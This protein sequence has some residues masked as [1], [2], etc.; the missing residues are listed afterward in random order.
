NSAAIRVVGQRSPLAVSQAPRHPEVDQENA[1]GFESDNQILAATVDGTDALAD[2]LCGDD[3]GRERPH[4]AR[5]AD[6]S[7]RDA[8]TLE[9]RGDVAANRL[10][11]GELR[12]PSSVAVPF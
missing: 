8:T 5:V 7:L 10:D 4:Q 6:G 9:H 11:L 1:P 2:Q 12:H 3:L